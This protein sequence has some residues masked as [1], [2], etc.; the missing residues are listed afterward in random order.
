MSANAGMSV[1]ATPPSAGDRTSMYAPMPRMRTA[2]SMAKRK[3]HV[4]SFAT[5]AVSFCIRDT[6]EAGA[7]SSLS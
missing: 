3:T 5:A 1:S 4:R 2:L 6:S 7:F